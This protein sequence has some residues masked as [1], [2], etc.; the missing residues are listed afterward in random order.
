LDPSLTAETVVP[1]LARLLT[2]GDDS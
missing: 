2:Q 1:V